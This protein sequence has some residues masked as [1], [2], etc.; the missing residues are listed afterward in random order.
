MVAHFDVDKTFA[1]IKRRIT[2]GGNAVGQR[3]TDKVLVVTERMS[4]NFILVSFTGRRQGYFAV[5][6]G[7]VNQIILTVFDKKDKIALGK[8]RAFVL[9]RN[10]TSCVARN[11]TVILC[12][13]GQRYGR[14]VDYFHQFRTIDKSLFSDTVL[15]KLFRKS[16]FH[17]TLTVAKSVF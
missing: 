4:V 2:D 9:S 17:Q 3:N 11:V 6:T 14:V 16:H 1:V 10:D 8:K 12:A 7:V 13:D 5:V 15:F